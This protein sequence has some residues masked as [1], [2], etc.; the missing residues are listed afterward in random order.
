MSLRLIVMLGAKAEYLGRAMV[1]VNEARTFEVIVYIIFHQDGGEVHLGNYPIRR[2]CGLFSLHLHRIGYR[3]ISHVYFPDVIRASDPT[4]CRVSGRNADNRLR[5]FFCL[6]V[7]GE[8]FLYLLFF[9]TGLYYSGREIP[10]IL[11]LTK[12][13]TL[14]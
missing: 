6:E 1:L 12:L 10:N 13:P 8:F 2:A 3:N 9:R 5:Q 11:L 14:Y 7:G 4:S